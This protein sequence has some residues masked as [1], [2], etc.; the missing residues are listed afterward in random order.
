MLFRDSSLAKGDAFLAMFAINSPESWYDVQKLRAKIIQEKDGDE[1]VP[2]VFIANKSVSSTSFK[3]TMSCM[4][5]LMQ[6]QELMYVT[7]TYSCNLPRGY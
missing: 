6:P 5:N 7:N 4:K 3:Y 1:R 2:M